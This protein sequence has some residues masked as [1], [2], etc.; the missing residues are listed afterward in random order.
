MKKVLD[1][2]FKDK[3]PEDRPTKVEIKLRST[4]TPEDRLTEDQWKAEYKIG[5]AI[6]NREGIHNAQS[7]MQL[8]DERT[9]CTYIKNKNIG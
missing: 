5:I 1:I 6:E 9:M 3:A 4:V 2:L 8:W 7:I